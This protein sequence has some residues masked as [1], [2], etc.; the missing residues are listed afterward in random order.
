MKIVF[1]I[2]LSG[3]C[4]QVVDLI[5]KSQVKIN[6]NGEKFYKLIIMPGIFPKTSV[7]SMMCMRQSNSLP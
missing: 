3:N 6:I 4:F 2:S 5:I 7:L 1:M